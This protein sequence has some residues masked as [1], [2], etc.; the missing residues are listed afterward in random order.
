[1]VRLLSCELRANG[2]GAGFE[3]QFLLDGELVS[4]RGGFPSRDL[5]I[6]WADHQREQWLAVS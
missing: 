1:M 3:V 2:E 6:L 5:A 4:A